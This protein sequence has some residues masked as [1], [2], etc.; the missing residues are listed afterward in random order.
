MEPKR[1]R[2]A[3]R[4]FAVTC[5]VLAAALSAAFT[6]Q[7]TL[8]WLSHEDSKNNRL[9][10]MQYIFSQKIKEEFVPPASLTGGTQ[11]E[12]RS[13]VENDGD[14]PFFV[15]V[16]VFPVLSSPDSPQHFEAQFGKQLRFVGLN[17]GL[18]ETNWMDGGDGW[19]YY[20]GV[21]PPGGQTEPLFEKVELD[22][23]VDAYPGAQLTVTLI[24]ETVEI[25][26]FGGGT[27]FHYKEA[28]WGNATAI[29]NRPAIAAVLDPLA[30]S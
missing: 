13:W 25:R 22:G 20:Y 1:G 2:R 21:V 14:V 17:V 5:A 4:V 23:S 19:F 15:R 16:K 29:G 9:G 7:G 10:I 24:A 12:K 27:R 8:A 11:V 18:D 6:I 30:A 28:W 3:L 26:K